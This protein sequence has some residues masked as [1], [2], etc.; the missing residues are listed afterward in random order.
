MDHKIGPKFLQ[1][2]TQI[3]AFKIYRDAYEFSLKFLIVFLSVE[4]L[5]SIL[6]L[7]SSPTLS[8]WTSRN[9]QDLEILTNAFAP[10]KSNFFTEETHR[11][12]N[13]TKQAQSRKILNSEEHEDW[14]IHYI[15][16]NEG[17]LKLGSMELHA[18]GK[19]GKTKKET[20]EISE[21][22]KNEC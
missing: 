2:C 5:L 6:S 14:A 4:I 11:K 22:H 15:G 19:S 16:K 18:L 10:G 20:S 7:V 1:I 21:E 3:L 17:W 13:G 9:K 8:E 12:G